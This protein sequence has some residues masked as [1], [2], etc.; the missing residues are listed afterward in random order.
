MTDSKNIE[1]CALYKLSN[2]PGLSWFKNIVLVSSYQDQYVPFDSARIQI[3][4]KASDDAKKGNAYIKM[5]QNILGNMKS[6]LLY[7][8]DVNF[9][10]SDK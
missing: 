7:R 4:K 8:L 2:S 6:R 9:K 10:I 1:E 5:A 3:C